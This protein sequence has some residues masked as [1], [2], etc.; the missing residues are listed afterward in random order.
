MDIGP[1]LRWFMIGLCVGVTLT[2]VV[3]WLCLCR[4]GSGYDACL[5]AIHGGD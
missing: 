5:D 3:M 2:Y 1:E 4:Q